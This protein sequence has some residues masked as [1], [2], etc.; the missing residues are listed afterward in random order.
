M[1]EPLESILDS[2]TRLVALNTR[3]TKQNETQLLYIQG[4]LQAASRIS[5]IS[6]Q[7]AINW[8]IQ[9]AFKSLENGLKQMDEQQA[10]EMLKRRIRGN[11]ASILGQGDAQLIMQRYNITTG[12]RK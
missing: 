12:G 7:A 4:W 2:S 9:E 10:K 6:K 1:S 8:A 11:E 5:K 3:I